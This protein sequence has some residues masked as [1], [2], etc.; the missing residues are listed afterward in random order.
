MTPTVPSTTTTSVQTSTSSSPPPPPVT[1]QTTT[2]NPPSTT[3][4]TLT[5]RS[6][7]N[8]CPSSLGGGC[9]HTDRVCAS[10]G[11][12]AYPPGSSPTTTSASSTMQPTTTG[13]GG[14]PVRPTSESPPGSTLTENCPVYFYAC[15]ARYGGGCC[16]TG[17]DC[18]VTSCPPT[19]Y[20]T[21]IDTSR[22]V[23]VP[24]GPAATVNS[25]TGACASGW[26]TCAPEVGGNCCPSGYQ[27]G[28]ASCTLVQ[29]SQT[30]V[31][32]KNSPS[33]GGDV[34]RVGVATICAG[35]L[36]VSAWLLL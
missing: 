6:D 35:V 9:C 8:P 2:S 18:Q 17:R 28:T 4:P 30:A 27:C 36:A 3:Q 12:C 29:A 1:T 32:G 20:T 31:A 16:Q 24:V 7:S 5:C 25:P 34:V 15:S 22:T 14:A 13:A 10:S 26:Q 21:I 19:Q 23:V 11:I 33:S